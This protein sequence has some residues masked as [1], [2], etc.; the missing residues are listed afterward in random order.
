MNLSK[1]LVLAAVVLFFGL[2]SLHHIKGSRISDIGLSLSAMTLALLIGLGVLHG[3]Y[4]HPGK[5]AHGTFQQGPSA[6]TAK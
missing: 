6:A 1:V 3:H 5:S 4:V 2:L